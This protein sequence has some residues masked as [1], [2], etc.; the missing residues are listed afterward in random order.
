MKE[1]IIAT[2][3]DESPDLS[4]DSDETELQDIVYALAAAPD[5]EQSGTCFAAQVTGLFRSLDKGR[6]WQD[7]YASLKLDSP[8]PT[9]AVA[10]SPQ[11]ETDRTVFAGVAGA[12]LRSSDG[13]QTWTIATLPSPPPIV[14][15]LTVSPNYAHDGMVFA[16]TLEDG[17]FYS[18]NRGERWVS[19]NFGLLDLRILAL[20]ISP[21]FAHDETL[22]VGTDSGIYRSTNGGRAWREVDFPLEFAPVLSLAI[23]PHFASDGILLAGTE[24][25]GLFRSND[26]GR[27]WARLG[28]EIITEAVNGIILSPQFP[29]PAD[30]LVMAG[31][32]L[33]VSRDGGQTWSQWTTELNLAEGLATVAAP[34]GLA[35]GAP[36][37][38]GLLDGRVLCI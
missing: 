24:A 38:V 30:V 2:M 9:A 31:D 29:T 36:L 33:L 34:Q 6:T 22:F 26:R 10:L 15:M 20:V 12:V 21:D 32:E 18:N 3:T 1:A 7:V 5:F 35:P 37:L 11:F 16:G 17:V 23:S 8:L 14:S 28:Q 27:T 19:W 13:G 25:N 4:L